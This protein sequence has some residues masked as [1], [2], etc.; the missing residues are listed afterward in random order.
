MNVVS[1][2]AH[3]ATALFA[4]FIG[5][6]ILL[7]AGVLPVTIAWGGRQPVLTPALRVA[8]VAAA[9]ILTFFIYVIRYRAGLM[10]QT[11]APPW[12]PI[13]AWGV[14]GFMALNTLG[15][16]ASVNKVERFVSGPLTVMIALA[17]LVI[18]AS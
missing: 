1:I 14:T 18:A 6:Q 9:L 11:P 5:M 13:A 16:F 17:C 2:A 10:G 8:S 7:A 15:N 3:V 4:I 12:I